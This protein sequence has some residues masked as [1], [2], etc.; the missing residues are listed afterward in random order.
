MANTEDEIAAVVHDLYDSRLIT[1]S[2]DRWHT[3]AVLTCVPV[4]GEEAGGVLW[5]KTPTV[6]GLS[7][8]RYDESPRP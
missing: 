8:S 3:V 6:S 4:W 7:M 1:V 2:T 5:T